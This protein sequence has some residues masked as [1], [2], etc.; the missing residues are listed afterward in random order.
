MNIAS[1]KNLF[2]IVQNETAQLQNIDNQSDGF[3]QT[4]S[5]LIPK[6]RISKIIK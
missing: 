2:V 5:R 6:R 3:V 4:N 1:P